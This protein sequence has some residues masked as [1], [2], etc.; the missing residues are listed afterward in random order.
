[1]RLCK[2]DIYKVV[3]VWAPKYSTN[4]VLINVNKVSDKV[5]HYLV[6]FTKA[7]VLKDW[8]YFSLHDIKKS[9]TQ[10]N[11]AGNMYAVSMDKS[12]QFT[13]IK[14]CEHVIK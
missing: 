14:D 1:M 2:H 8:Y 13:P 6:K 7:P 4:Q 3:E 5:D 11:G 10:K 9:S 12:Q